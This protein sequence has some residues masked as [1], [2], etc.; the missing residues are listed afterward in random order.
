M[1]TSWQNSL[2]DEANVNTLND[3][4]LTGADHFAI[5]MLSTP[6][7]VVTQLFISILQANTL[8][9]IFGKG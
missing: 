2:Y 9:S 3:H 5:T 6:N 4:S 1:K 8:G 7:S